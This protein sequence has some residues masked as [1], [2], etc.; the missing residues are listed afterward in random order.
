MHRTATTLD[1]APLHC[2]LIITKITPPADLPNWLFWLEDMGFMA[3]ERTQVKRRSYL[4]NGALVVQ[5][6]LSTFALQAV[7]AHC[8]EVIAVEG[9]Q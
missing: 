6:G 5:V 3:G 7:E 1:K 8:V 4:N 9:L 2:P